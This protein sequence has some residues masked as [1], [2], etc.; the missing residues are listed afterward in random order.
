MFCLNFYA[1][2]SLGRG[3]TWQNLRGEHSDIILQYNISF[4]SPL[5]TQEVCVLQESAE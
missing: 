5:E 1:G 2:L 3:D 4:T